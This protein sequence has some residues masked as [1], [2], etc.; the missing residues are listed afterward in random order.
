MGLWLC[1]MILGKNSE[2]GIMF[3]LHFVRSN[4]FGLPKN[5]NFWKVV[6]VSPP[7]TEKNCG[8]YLSS[9]FFCR[10][11][12]IIWIIENFVLTSDKF[13]DNMNIIIIILAK[14]IKVVSA[15]LRENKVE[16]YLSSGIFWRWCH[17]IW[18]IVNFAL[19]P[20]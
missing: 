13:V 9:E 8:M 4:S 17:K 18:I 14:A 2:N 10:W 5:T 20:K 1:N 6:M 3:N 19:T 7:L 16:M 12:H 15:Q 11:C